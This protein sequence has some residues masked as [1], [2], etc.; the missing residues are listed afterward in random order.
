MSYVLW[1]HWLAD[2]RFERELASPEGPSI[3]RR[4][5]TNERCEAIHDFEG[6]A[7]HVS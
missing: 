7:M 3:A 6:V 5:V 2:G 4:G 1:L